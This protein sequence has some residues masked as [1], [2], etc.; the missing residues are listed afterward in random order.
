MQ[1]AGGRHRRVL[2]SSERSKRG[3]REEKEARGD[4][5]IR[6]WFSPSWSEPPTLLLHMDISSQT[7]ANA[8]LLSYQTSAGMKTQEESCF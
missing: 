8:D 2:S 5:R 6:G 1:S 4:V 3:G 7:F